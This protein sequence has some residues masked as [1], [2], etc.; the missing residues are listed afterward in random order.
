MKILGGVVAPTTGTIRVDGA[1]QRALTVADAIARR[2]RLRPPGAQP[3]R[4]SRRRRQHLHRPRAA[5]RRAAEARRPAA[6]ARRGRAA[7]R[8]ARRRLRARHAG[9]RPVARPAAA[10]RDRQGAVAQRA[11]RHHGRADLEPDARRD[12][13]GCSQSSPSSR[14]TASASSSSRTG[15]TRSSAAPTASSC[16]ATARVVGELR[17]GEIEPRRDDPAD[18]RPRPEVAL[19]AAGSAPPGDAVLELDGPAHRGLSR[20]RPSTSPSAR[21]E[22]LGLAGLVGSGR[23]ELAR[24]VF[25]IDRPLGGA[26]RLDG[27]AARD[28][29]RRA[30]PS[31][32][33]STSCPRT[34]SAPASCS[35]CRSPRTSRCRTCRPIAARPGRP[36]RRESRDAPSAARDARHPGA[37]R[38]HAG[39]H[40]VGRQPAEGRARQVAVDEAAGHD[41]RRADARHRRRRQERDLRADARRSPTPASPS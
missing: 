26:I 21:G 8:A 3:L 20:A 30:T 5:A 14:P 27:A 4:Q 6:A 22:I 39:R 23:T 41:L 33:A 18:D 11:A 32:A 17:K 24:A 15:W 9:R 10:G 28:R 29:A 19:H 35:T 16:C 13:R 40:A 1:E 37:R 25:G 36:P 38:R 12:R 34:A 7:A 31:T 2:H